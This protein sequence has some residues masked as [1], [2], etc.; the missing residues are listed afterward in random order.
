[1]KMGAGEGEANKERVGRD[2][3]RT[4]AEFL[5]V[6]GTKVLRVF[7]LDIHSHL[8]EQQ[9]WFE[10]GLYSN[11]YIAYGSLKSESLKIMPR[12]LNEI[13]RS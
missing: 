8:Y 10:T 7:L 3:M 9:R 2:R 12:N 5:G 11:V 13:V 6:N 1:M 4:K